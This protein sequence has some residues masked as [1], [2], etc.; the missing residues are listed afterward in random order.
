M[1]AK[2][3]VIFDNLDTKPRDNQLSFE[4]FSGVVLFEPMILKCFMPP[5]IS[6]QDQVSGL[7]KLFI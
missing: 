1:D 4:E 6:E 3:D 7:Y 2:I 5:K